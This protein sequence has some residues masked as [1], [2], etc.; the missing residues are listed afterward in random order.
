MDANGAIA[1]FGDNAQMMLSVLVFLAAGT[2]VF[3]AMVAIR[4]R[5]AVRRRAVRISLDGAT[6]GSRRSLSYAGLRTAQK[7]VDYAAKHYSFVEG[8]DVKVLRR[9]LMQAGIYSS[10]AAA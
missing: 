10:R 7:L 8:S 1:M 6:S 2:L 9:R 5:E 3:A 4:A